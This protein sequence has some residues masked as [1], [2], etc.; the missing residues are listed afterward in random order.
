MEMRLQRFLAQAGVASRRKCEELIVDGQVS[1]NGKV[2]TELGTKVDSRKDEVF[3]AGRRVRAE[4]H[5]YILM[6]KPRGCVTTMADPEGRETVTQIIGDVGARIYPVG[7]L[8]F[9]TEGLLVLTNDGDLANALMHPSHEVEKTYE[10][11]L[12]GLATAEL[13]EGF[14]A[15]VVLDDGARTAPAQAQMLGESEGGHNSWLEVTIHEGKNRQIHR[16]AEALGHQVAKL[17]RIRY[18][19]LDLTG[20]RPGKWRLLHDDEVAKLRKSVGLKVERPARERG[21]EAG[22]V[23]AAQGRARRPGAT[24]SPRR[25]AGGAYT[26]KPA[27]GAYAKK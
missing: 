17:K 8:D 5:V 24:G 10:V 1:V 16:M 15:G 26:K 2:V 19:G 4:G 21:A 13:I 20:V 18:A 3:V 14:Q 9:N 25:P 23:V 12:R 7:R 27:G 6:N 11:K 22:G